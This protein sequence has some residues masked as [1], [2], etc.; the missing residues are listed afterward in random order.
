MDKEAKEERPAKKFRYDKIESENFLSETTK[1]N[2]LIYLNIERKVPKVK[3][4][5]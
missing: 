2:I 3:K 1:N 4:P 5:E